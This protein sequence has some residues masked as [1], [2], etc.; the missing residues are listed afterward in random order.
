VTATNAVAA[1]A[2]TGAR[3]EMLV[4]L[5]TRHGRAATV[6]PAFAKHVEP[7]ARERI[8]KRLVAAGASIVNDP[9]ALARTARTVFVVVPSWRLREVAAG[10]GPH[11]GGHHAVV[12]TCTALESTSHA[13]GSGVIREE[14]PARLVGALVGPIHAADHLLG[15]PGAAVVGSR[16]PSVIGSVQAALADPMFRVYGNKDLTG[17]EVGGAVADVLAVAV[18]LAD[19]LDLGA[20][21]RGTVFARGIA[22]LERIGAAFG[23]VSGTLTGMAGLG[24]L[25]ATTAAPIGVPMRIGR[26]LASGKS[27]KEVLERFPRDGR[28]LVA[29]CETVRERA[30]GGRVEAHI[31]GAIAGVLVDGE[32]PADAVRRLLTLGQMME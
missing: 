24:Y 30:E 16:F 15:K 2:G 11:L 19:G 12:H 5:I 21:V 8:A 10:L 22:E 7:K 27:V 3:A 23:A 9:A 18:G 13:T 17:V 14:T 26:A 4:H 32:S 25:A 6:W 31:T 28:E 29:A 20:S 1:I